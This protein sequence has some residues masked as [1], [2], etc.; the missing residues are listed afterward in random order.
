[1]TKSREKLLKYVAAEIYK[2]VNTDNKLDVTSKC[3]TLLLLKNWVCDKNAKIINSRCK[4]LGF[5]V[6][7][8]ICD[9]CF[10]Y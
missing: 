2:S 5:N 9:Y 3:N 4:A 8:M 10:S 1:M 6:V 7:F